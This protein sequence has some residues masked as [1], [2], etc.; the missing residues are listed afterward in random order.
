MSTLE[1]KPRGITEQENLMRA[2]QRFAI[3]F[4]Q[5]RRWTDEVKRL[6]FTLN[7]W[8][9]LALAAMEFSESQKP[10]KNP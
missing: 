3:A 7:V 8:R 6:E 9:E 1:P 10:D 4:D 5:D 2:A